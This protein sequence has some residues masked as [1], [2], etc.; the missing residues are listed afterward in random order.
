RFKCD[1]SSDVC[2]SDLRTIWLAISF[3]RWPAAPT[4]TPAQQ[5]CP[6]RVTKG[7]DRTVTSRFRRR[8]DRKLTVALFSGGAPSLVG[9]MRPGTDRKSV[10]EGKSVGWG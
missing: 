5:H 6:G 3:G 2:S 9:R 7:C 1:C 4:G 8:P 10:V